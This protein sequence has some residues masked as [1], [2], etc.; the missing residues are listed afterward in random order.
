[1]W[2]LYQSTSPQLWKNWGREGSY[3][4]LLRQAKK[5]YF[6]AL[7]QLV[8]SFGLWRHF[9]MPNDCLMQTSLVD[10]T[11]KVPLG[12]SC[13]SQSWGAAKA[14]NLPAFICWHIAEARK[15]FPWPSSFLALCWPHKCLCVTHMW[16]HGGFQLALFGESWNNTKPLGFVCLTRWNYNR[17]MCVVS[18]YSCHI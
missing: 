3:W 13:W 8:Q 9:N 7:F 15:M 11:W 16:E 4:P 6:W 10:L 2:Y 18:M 17:E 5:C 14:Y 1:M 12:V